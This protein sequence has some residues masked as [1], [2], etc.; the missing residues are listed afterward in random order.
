M[1]TEYHYGATQQIAQTFLKQKLVFRVCYE[2][3]YE[4]ESIELLN[5]V[6]GMSPIKI[7]I[8]I[9]DDDSEIVLT[10]PALF[11][12]YSA[13]KQDELMQAVNRMNRNLSFSKLIIPYEGRIDVRYVFPPKMSDDCIG[14]AVYE[15]YLQI[16]KELEEAVFEIMGVIRPKKNESHNFIKYEMPSVLQKND[17]HLKKITGFQVVSHD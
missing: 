17:N 2:Q 7:Q 4:C 6:S 8:E 3:E 13:E 1:D 11:S 15:V 5:D 10:I 9:F 14:E 16:L 12:G